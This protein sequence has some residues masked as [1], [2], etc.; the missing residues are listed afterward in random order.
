MLCT[1]GL[2][3]AVSEAEILTVLN[4]EDSS[5]QAVNK[6]IA[7]ANEKGGEDNITVLMFSM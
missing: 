3:G 1:D 7:L 6:L 2:H 5:E 4:E